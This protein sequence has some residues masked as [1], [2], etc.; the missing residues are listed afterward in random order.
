MQIYNIEI[1]LHK[2]FHPLMIL[3]YQI[4]IFTTLYI[5]DIIEFQ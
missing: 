3:L 5:H 4:H 2:F 1:Q